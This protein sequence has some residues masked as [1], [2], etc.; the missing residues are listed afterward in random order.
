M[1][2]LRDYFRDPLAVFRLI[3][4][5]GRTDCPI[6]SDAKALSENNLSRFVPRFGP[7][8]DETIEGKSRHSRAMVRFF[9]LR[10]VQRWPEDGMRNVQVVFTQSLI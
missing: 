9:R 2:K 1:D 8:L 6:I 4:L 7:D 5:S 3:C 10:R